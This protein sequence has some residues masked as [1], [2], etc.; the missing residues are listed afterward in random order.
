[1]LAIKIIQVKET[2]KELKSMQKGA[3]N[4]IRKRLALLIALKQAKHESLS[5]RVLSRLL[6]IDANSVTNWKRLYEQKGMNGILEDKRGG[7]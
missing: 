2:L 1:M 6:G 7:F 4:P 3:T 5:K